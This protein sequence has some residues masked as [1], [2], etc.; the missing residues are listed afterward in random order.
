VHV[1]LPELLLLKRGTVNILIAVYRANPLRPH[2]GH[3]RHVWLC[4]ALGFNVGNDAVPSRRCPAK[5][6]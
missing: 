3:G 5:D 2:C 6:N 1:L 4:R